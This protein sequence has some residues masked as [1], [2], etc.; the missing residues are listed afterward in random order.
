MVEGVVADEAF[1]VDADGDE[2]HPLGAGRELAQPCRWYDEDHRAAR[3]VEWDVDCTKAGFARAAQ[4]EV[5]LRD[6]G[7]RCPQPA[8]HHVV[9]GRDGVGHL[10]DLG[11]LLEQQRGESRHGELL[12][13]WREVL[14]VADISTGPRLDHL[15][16]ADCL[17]HLAE[18]ERSVI[19]LSF[20]EER[21]ADDVAS[22]MGTTAGNV[23][24]IR[25]RALAHLRD[26][27]GGGLLQ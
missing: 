13:Q 15:R 24:V 23:R 3:C 21:T 11:P 25:H 4:H 6:A 26:C 16:V 10:E 5:D 22:T 8:D 17:G 19:V 12:E 1:S 9:L 7:Q 2:L 14:E 27:M 20:Y 18:R